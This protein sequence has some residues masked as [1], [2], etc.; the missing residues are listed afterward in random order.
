MA[1]ENRMEAATP[2]PDA[3]AGVPQAKERRMAAAMPRPDAAAKAAAVGIEAEGL[4]AQLYGQE[5]YGQESCDPRGRSGPRVSGRCAR[6]LDRQ[7]G[8]D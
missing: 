8:Q 2:R 1:G 3:M 4:S 6:S 7:M 5:L